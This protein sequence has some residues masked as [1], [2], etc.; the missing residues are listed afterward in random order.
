MIANPARL[1]GL[2]CKRVKSPSRAGNGVQYGGKSPMPCKFGR[3]NTMFFSMKNLQIVAKDCG[4]NDGR[5]EL[6]FAGDYT[7]TYLTPFEIAALAGV[8]KTEKVVAAIFAAI[9]EETGCE[10]QYHGLG[11]ALSGSENTEDCRFKTASSSDIEKQARKVR[12]A[13][14]AVVAAAKATWDA[15]PDKI[16]PEFIGDV[17]PI[18][19][20]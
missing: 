8:P 6:V 3:Q 19:I 17:F 4:L 18:D 15:D 2:D 16:T 12:K 10:S 20:F 11:M 1:G 13:A 5:C 14:R 9:K 7:G